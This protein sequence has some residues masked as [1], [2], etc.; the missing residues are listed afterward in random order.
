M[1]RDPLD[2]WGLNTS[3]SLRKVLEL[4]KTEPVVQFY[5]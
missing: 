2:V 1:N 3:E 4:T 5:H